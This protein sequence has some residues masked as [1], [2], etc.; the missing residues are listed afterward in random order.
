MRTLLNQHHIETP[1]SPVFPAVELQH[2]V[3]VILLV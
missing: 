3:V 2:L 1:T